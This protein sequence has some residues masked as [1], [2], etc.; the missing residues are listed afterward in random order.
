M[1][2][3]QEKPAPEEHDRI[4]ELLERNGI[5]IYVGARTPRSGPVGLF[6]CLDEQHDDAVALLRNPH[7]TVANPVDV[8]DYYKQ[9]DAA[10]RQT[11]F[12]T[13]TMISIIVALVM[14]VAIVFFIRTHA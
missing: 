3:L 2:W 13:A 8:A 10:L 9:L 7:H 4:R 6:V 11:P 12:S 14:I 5:P 1:R